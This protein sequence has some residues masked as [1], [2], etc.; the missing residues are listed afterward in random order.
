MCIQYKVLTF[1]ENTRKIH[2][3]DPTP[4]TFVDTAQPPEFFASFRQADD[5]SDASNLR[6]ILKT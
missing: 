3:L 1:Q 2:Y 4:R 6:R 5:E